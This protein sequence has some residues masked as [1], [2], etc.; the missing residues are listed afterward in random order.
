MKIKT[1]YC[2][3][4]IR[5]FRQRNDEDAF[6]M[7]SERLAKSDAEIWDQKL[8]ALHYYSEKM[9]NRGDLWFLVNIY[10]ANEN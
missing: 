1:G 9:I 5:D 3:Y 4:D 2:E 8:T 7:V 6:K 10:R